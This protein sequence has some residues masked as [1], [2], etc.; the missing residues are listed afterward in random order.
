MWYIAAF[1]IAGPVVAILFGRAAQLG[2]SQEE[3]HQ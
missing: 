2:A 3:A 1:L